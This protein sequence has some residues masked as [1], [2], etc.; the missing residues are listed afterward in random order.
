MSPWT[1]PGTFSIIS[2]IEHGGGIYH[3][4]GGLNRLSHGMAEAF[5]QSGGEI[6]LST[7]VKKIMVENKKATGVQ[8][9]NGKVEKSD[10]VVINA[11]FAHAMTRLVDEKDRKKWTDDRLMGKDYSCSTFMLYLGVKKKF[12][13]IPHHSII[14]AE[15][16][17]RN[18]DEITKDMILSDDFSFYVQNAS[19][20]DKTLAP[21]GGSTIYVLVPVPNNKSQIIWNEKKQA[22]RNSVIEA[23]ET[24]GGFRGLTDNIEE[25]EIKT[26]EDWAKDHSVYL[27][28]TFNLAHSVNQMLYF[29]PHNEF[30]EFKN[31]YLVGGGTHPGRWYESLMF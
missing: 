16:Y 26:P 9:E 22:F 11:D 29:R 3:V 1:A 5:K 8:L 25:E 19:V 15:D 13:D 28:A 12:D 23:L 14:F 20:T 27:G 30:E 21:E 31:C 10:Y 4:T 17:K 18:I 7:P 24:K 2:Y 6:H